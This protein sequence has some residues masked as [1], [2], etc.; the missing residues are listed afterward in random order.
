VAAPTR[1]ERYEIVCRVGAGGMGEVFLAR[2]KGPA[3]FER[4]VAVKRVVVEADRARFEEL[5]AREARLAVRL[6]HANVVRVLDLVRED[7][8]FWLVMEWVPGVDLRRLASLL[9]RPLSPVEAVGLGTQLLEGL[10]AAHGLRDPETGV[11]T[12][13]FHCDVSPTNAL[14]SAAGL[15]KLA[16]FGVAHAARDPSPLQGAGKVRYMAPETLAGGAP[17]ASADLYGAALV[18]WE[19]LAGRPPFEDTDAAAS[20][21]AKRAGAPALR[22]VRPDAPAALGAVLLRALDPDRGLRYGSAEGLAVALRE[23]V[24]ATREEMDRAVA[25]IATSIE[26]PTPTEASKV[27]EHTR[28]L[29]AEG[30]VIAAGPVS[31]RPTAWAKPRRTRRIAFA[32][33]LA[34]ILAAA[35]GFALVDGP[36]DAE[37]PTTERP[38]EPWRD[39]LP[40]MPAPQGRRIAVAAFDASGAQAEDRWIES[41]VPREIAAR[42]EGSP[43]TEVLHL[44]RAAEDLVRPLQAAPVHALAEALGASL[45]VTGRIESGP[46]V[47]IEIRS[48]PAQGSLANVRLDARPEGLLAALDGWLAQ[49]P[50]GLG[51]GSRRVELA[52]TD[53]V[54]LLR[55]YRATDLLQSE[56]FGAAIAALQEI[57]RQA[58][59]EESG[60]LAL[61]VA[62]W[63]KDDPEVAEAALRRLESGEATAPV[64]R[65]VRKLLDEDAC[66]ALE[67]LGAE[68]PDPSVWALYVRAEAEFHCGALDDAERRFLRILSVAPGFALAVHHPLHRAMLRRDESALGALQRRTMLREPLSGGGESLAVGADI[69]LRRYDAAIARAERVAR[70]LVR[71][72]SMPMEIAW[73]HLL[74]GRPVR[75]RE[76]VV[77][78]AKGATASLSTPMDPYTLADDLRILHGFPIPSEVARA[79]SGPGVSTGQH[80]ARYAAETA[81]REHLLGRPATIPVPPP[82]PVPQRVRRTLLLLGLLLPGADPPSASELAHEPDLRELA[83][84]RTASEP[85]AAAE[86]ADRAAGLDP[87]GRFWPVYQRVRIDRLREA[88]DADGAARACDE[89]LH[90]AL[91]STLWS[92]AATACR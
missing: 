2:A 27:D 69:A 79:S 5:L 28:T 45:L 20:L 67:A 33:L 31:D 21:E 36:E 6:D 52:S 76:T 83:R 90:P 15:V 81:V 32:A 18:V 46:R 25:G 55:W 61:A 62:V 66:G 59:E 47:R 80:A 54:L 44:Y 13:I 38:S 49:R 64:A 35:G 88:G 23:S 85:R 8:A 56:D 63:W 43:D 24:D 51:P 11:A 1:V 37:R 14:L 71:K 73:A 41:L 3:G 19:I 4:R 84:A 9:R 75:A 65:A 92:A 22:T 74:A 86:A 7:D 34:V 39:L 58:P 29:R 91:H 82:A 72:T 53:P 78:V 12:P 60:W 42:L 68:Q 89:L 17:S 57:T 40:E 10:R 50:A 48:L 16:D 30:S 26:V 77:A 70:R 87:D